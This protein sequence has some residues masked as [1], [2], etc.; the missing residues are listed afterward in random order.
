MNVLLA[1]CESWV[2]TDVA[3]AVGRATDAR[4]LLL[5]LEGEVTGGEKVT[6]NTMRLYLRSMG[7]LVTLEEHITRSPEDAYMMPDSIQA[8]NLSGFGS[9]T[10]PTYLKLMNGKKSTRGGIK[11][12][13]L[14]MNADSVSVSGRRPKRCKR[15]CS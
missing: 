14:A 4:Q 10:L 12:S 6:K 13:F 15:N 5:S 2:C 1:T 9:V 11:R 7:L 3:V 8:L